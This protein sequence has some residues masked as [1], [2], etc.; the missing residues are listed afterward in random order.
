MTRAV[1]ELYQ[2]VILDHYRKPRNLGAL[3]DAPRAVGINPLC[4]DRITVY[5]RCSGQ[6][7]TEATFEGVGCA[8]CIA[9]ASLM[10]ETVR[11]K[12]IADV[13]RLA[14]Q[15]RDLVMALPAVPVNDLGALTALAGVRQ[16]PVRAKCALLPWQ[17]LDAVVH[18]RNE[19]VSTE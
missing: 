15:V 12:T 5:A 7:V 10:T 19:V 11:G 14:A 18:A 4:G 3:V 6:L 1:P 9:S 8:I 17:T 16:F 13:D 2:Q